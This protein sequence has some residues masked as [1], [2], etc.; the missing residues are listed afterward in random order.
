MV[1]AAEKATVRHIVTEQYFLQPLSRTFHGRDVFAPV[2]AYLGAGVPPSRFGPL[3]EDHLRLN[4]GQAT[5]TGKRNWTGS[6]LKVDH[7]GNLITNL[8]IDEFPDVRTR[9]FEMNVGLQTLTRL[10]L[11]FSEGT[12]GELFVIVGSSGFLEVAANQASAAKVL[13]CGVGSPAELVLY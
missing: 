10:A 11:T 12:Q 7:F 3:I 1:F 8:H 2:A 13:G 6:V 4:I 5:R 9:P